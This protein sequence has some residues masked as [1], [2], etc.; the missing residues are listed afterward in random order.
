MGIE[1]AKTKEADLTVGL[2]SILDNVL[3]KEQ[4]LL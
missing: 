1:L 3:V 2:F 4:K